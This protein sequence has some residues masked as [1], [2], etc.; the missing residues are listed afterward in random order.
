MPGSS[1][2]LLDKWNYWPSRDS[3]LRVIGEGKLKL[4]LPI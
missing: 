1:G 4:E 3:M 2:G